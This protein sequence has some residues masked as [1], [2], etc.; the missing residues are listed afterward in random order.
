M[1]RNC[2][3]DVFLLSYRLALGMVLTNGFD[4][5]LV[6]NSFFKAFASLKDIELLSDI[7]TFVIICGEKSHIRE[8][9]ISDMSGDEI[10][11]VFWFCR[12]NSAT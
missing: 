4:I 6:Y 1:L 2:T 5:L 7:K 12:I 10:C 9:N 3:S 8:S 11:R